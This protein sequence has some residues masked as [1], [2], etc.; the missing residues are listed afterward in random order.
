MVRKGKNIM[1]EYSFDELVK[2]EQ[3]K[4]S[5]E[6]K[7]AKISEHKMKVIEPVVVNS[8]FMKVKLDEAREQMKH[9]TITVDYDNGGGQKG[10]REN[11]VFK[12]YEALWKSYMLGMDKIL[13]IIPEEQQE[14]L[15][16]K[17]EE[18]KPQTVLDL[19]REKKKNPA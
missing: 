16:A 3:R 4:I 8:A 18:L 19:V 12:A 15:A 1:K 14:E 11:P 9:G 17:T 7:K 13:G 6:I 10:V 5:R 2:K